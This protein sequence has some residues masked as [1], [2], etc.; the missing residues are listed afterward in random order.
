MGER[1][2][3]NIALRQIVEEQQRRIAELEMELHIL[4]LNKVARQCPDRATPAD[5]AS[6][7]DGAVLP[8]ASSVDVAGA[9][10]TFCSDPPVLFIAMQHCGKR[11]LVTCILCDQDPTK[12]LFTHA[13][14]LLGGLLGCKTNPVE[15][16]L[17]DAR[18][19]HQIQKAGERW[20]NQQVWSI[21]AH[22]EMCNGLNAIGV[23]SNKKRVERAARL[24]L[25]ASAYL[26]WHE[27][28]GGVLPDPTADGAFEAL[29]ERVRQGQREQC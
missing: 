19:W 23:G 24:A 6:S 9:H 25:A 28:T 13:W 20:Q 2:S 15:Q 8:V 17:E 10:V 1:H 7:S 16:V 4:R 3:E 26:L 18:V 22:G 29:V 27:S 11:D 21:L 14:S 5:A 12:G